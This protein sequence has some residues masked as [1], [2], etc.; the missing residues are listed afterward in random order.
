MTFNWLEEEENGIVELKCC[1]TQRNRMGRTRRIMSVMF[2]N[3]EDVEETKR[4]FEINRKCVVNGGAWEPIEGGHW[5][6]ENNQWIVDES[7]IR[8][9]GVAG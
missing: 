7:D 9:L 8:L 2:R 5:H 6:F 4:E 3:R 1:H